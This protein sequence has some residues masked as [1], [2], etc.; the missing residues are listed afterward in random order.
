M[1][2]GIR[3]RIHMMLGMA[4]IDTVDD[5]TDIQLVKINGLSEEIQEG[6][7]RVQNYGLTSNPPQES[8]CI[9]NSMSGNKDNTKVV[10]C[11]SGKYRKK[12][13]KT[14]EVALYHKDGNFVYFKED[15]TLHISASDG[16]TISGDSEIEGDLSV[17]GNISATG[18]ISSSG[19]DSLNDFK[20]DYEIFKTTHTHSGVTVGGGVT[21][22]PVPT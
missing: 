8:E 6:I 3:A 1:F 10:G 12:N 21:G 2:E 17:D 16:V 11:D 19:C 4:T 9:T 7:E 5:T 14:G 20:A 18:D 13:L 15:G 22:P